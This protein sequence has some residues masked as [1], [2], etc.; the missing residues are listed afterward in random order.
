MGVYRS[1]SPV[2][3]V[4][5]PDLIKEV[6]IKSFQHFHDNDIDVDKKHDPLFGRNPLVLRGEEWKTVRAQLTPGFT[7]GKVSKKLQ[8]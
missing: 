7:S 6:T 5:D 8:I 1:L 2:L 4:R 3:L